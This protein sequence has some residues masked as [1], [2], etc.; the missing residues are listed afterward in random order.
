MKRI[1]YILFLIGVGFALGVGY[2]EIRAELISRWQVHH[3]QTT[4]GTQP[5][6]RNKPFV[7]VTSNLGAED[8]AE[9]NL[10]SI[11]NQD[12]S[13]FRVIY[14]DDS[15]EEPPSFIERF[16]KDKN[17]HYIKGGKSLENFYKAIHECN[18]DEVVIFLKEGEVL[19]HRDVL[20]HLNRYFADTN[21]WMI[22]GEELDQSSFNKMNAGRS[23]QAFYAGLFKAITLQ[24]FLNEGTFR[25]EGLDVVMTKHLLDLSGEH[26]F[27]IPEPIVLTPFEKDVIE[28][29]SLPKLERLKDYPWHDFA[30]DE[31]RVEVVVF[32]SDRPMQLYAFL[33]SAQDHLQN[34]HRLIAVYKACNEHYEK[35]YQKVKEKFHSVE[36]YRQSVENPHEDMAPLL[37]KLVFG[38]SLPSA[39][40][41]VFALD[42]N[43]IK[44]PIDLSQA[45]R[46]LKEAGA[47]GFYFRLGSNLES[48]DDEQR[49]F[50][51]YG[52]NAW[53]FLEGDGVWANANSV[54]MALF[55]KDEIYPAFLCMKFHTPNILQELWNEHADL[56]RVGLYFD[57]SKVVTL[58][59]AFTAESEEREVMAKYHSTKELLLYFDQGLKIDI[60]S[61][62]DVQSEHVEVELM[63][64]FIKR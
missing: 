27:L 4:Y 35:G 63:P 15:F 2:R 47:Y 45:V 19:A 9:Q 18:S 42:D 16:S 12:Y 62:K 7:V 46:S 61:L 48:H 29:G 5:I 30:E 11:L 55:R 43:I 13:D 53:Q 22:S 10:L 54:D 20:S 56:S 34:S 31:E 6:I 50:L 59:R 38:Y 26:A 57:E 8:I 23:Y 3:T 51:G 14:I 44:D 41:V 40:Y 37:Q 21:V 17:I 49:I 25:K 32:S 1:L 60:E 33:E 36:F 58:P 28:K 39:K 52:V 64:E 24:Y